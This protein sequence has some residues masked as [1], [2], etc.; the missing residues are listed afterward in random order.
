MSQELHAMLR[1]NYRNSTIDRLM[2][3]RD[4]AKIRKERYQRE[5][6]HWREVEQILGQIIGERV[7]K[8]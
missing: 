1:H 8:E 4:L 6:D 5:M 3:E 7:R 2:N